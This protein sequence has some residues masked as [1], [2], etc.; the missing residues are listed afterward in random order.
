MN[1]VAQR[2]L[3][4]SKMLQN[5]FLDNEWDFSYIHIMMFMNLL[6]TLKQVR[7]AA[8]HGCAVAE[9]GFY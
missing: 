5:K 8:W 7:M 6:T 3:V 9:G 1:S 4:L 2:A